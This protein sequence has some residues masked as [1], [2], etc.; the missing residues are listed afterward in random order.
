V[1]VVAIAKGRLLELSLD[2]FAKAG[3][4]FVDNVQTSR[5]LIF[6]AKDGSHRIVLVKPSDVSTYVEYGAADAGIAGLD[7]LMESRAD[8]VQPLALKFGYCRIAVAAQKGVKSLTG[9]ELPTVRVATKY[10][11]IT[12][13]FFNS[14][15]IAVEII[16]LNGSIELAP[17][18]GLADRI[19]DLV[20]SGQTLKE[21]GL[22]IVEVIAESS[23]RLIVNRAS[24]QIKRTAVLNF[25]EAIKQ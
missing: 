18:V 12:M 4:H 13:E 3:I 1:L 16:P 6:D 19:V 22:E 20:E 24:Y 17:L 11:N 8:V 23:A 15:G 5:K 21:N 2:L 7:V 9:S 10:P 25:I 14:R